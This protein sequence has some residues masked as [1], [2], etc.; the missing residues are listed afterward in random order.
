MAYF[1]TTGKYSFIQVPGDWKL[2]SSGL[3]QSLCHNR[4]FFGSFKC[5]RVLGLQSLMALSNPCISTGE[6]QT[7]S[8]KCKVSGNQSLAVCP[9]ALVT[10]GKSRLIHMLHGHWTAVSYCLL[11]SLHHY[12][13]T[14]FKWNFIFAGPCPRILFF[15]SPQSYKKSCFSRLSPF[16]LTESRSGQC[17]AQSNPIYIYTYKTLK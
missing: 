3:F 17:H 13:K 6:K 14:M 11:Q 2:V 10:T 1:I 5:C 12:W 4:K 7:H 9:N 8:L 16:P 15:Q